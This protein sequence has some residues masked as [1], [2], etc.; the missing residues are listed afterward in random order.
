M[1][2]EQRDS[3]WRRFWTLRIAP[4][5]VAALLRSLDWSWRYRE[6]GREHIDKA[7]AADGPVLIAALH[8]RLWTVVRTVSRLGGGGWLSMASRSI[9]GEA[10]T[11]TF[12][13]FGV[14]MVRGSSASGGAGAALALMRRLRRSSAPGAALTVDGSRGPR[15]RVQA[16]I[17][18]IASRCGGLIVPMTA[19]AKPA[20]I[21]RRAWDRSLL[22]KPFARV[23]ILYGEPIEVP[24]RIDAAGAK[25]LA[26]EIEERLVELQRRGDQMSGFGDDEPV[27]A[28]V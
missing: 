19:A 9:D 12:D 16:G 8:G 7:L 18:Q 3:F 15:G 4:F 13:R 22:P 14:E 26:L 20:W 11:R 21:F 6:T 2:T 23:D 27:R 25:T 5:A 28:A 24:A 1:A 10:I 17:V